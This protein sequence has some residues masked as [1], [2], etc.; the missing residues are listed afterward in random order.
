MRVSAAIPLALTVIF[1]CPL[2]DGKV[3]YVDDDAVGNNDGSS[4]ENAYNYLQDAITIVTGGDLILVA[5]G[6]YKPDQGIGITLGD[7]RTSFHLKNGVAIKG[8]YAGF[9][10]MNPDTRDVGL[11][12]TILSGDL[13]GDDI[14][15]NDPCDLRN[16]PSRADNSSHVVTG[17]NT[18]KTAVLD[19]F[20]ITAG[21]LIA[22]PFMGNSNPDGGAGMYISSGSPTVVDCIF[23]GNATNG[24]G[25]GTINIADSYPTIVNCTF[26]RNYAGGG[27]GISFW[28][29]PE[30]GNPTL[31]D[32]MFDDNYASGDGGGMYNYQSNPNLAN[33]T[34]HCN[35]SQSSG[36]GIYNKMSK[37]EL[38]ECT[39]SENTGFSG[40][41]MYSEDQ[42]ILILMN[43]VF[44][45]NSAEWNG[46]GMCNEDTNDLILTDCTFSDNSA[47]PNGGG[48]FSRRS[49]QMLINCIFSGNKAH[50]GPLPYTYPGK[51]AGLYT[52]GDAEII[53]CVFRNNWASEGAGIYYFQGALTVAG[54]TFTGNSAENYGGG[55]YN[56][57]NMPDLTITNCTF[58][59]NYAEW[60]GGIFNCWRSHLKMSNCT[61]TGNIASNGNAL[62]C[63]PSFTTLPRSIELTNCILWNGNNTLFDPK[64]DDSTIAIAYSDVQ[65]G[66]PG[67]GNI[68][69]NPL[70]ANPGYWA[71]ADDSNIAAEPNDPNAVWIDGDYH[72][73]SQAGRWDPSS[74]SW[75]VDDVT[76]LCIDAGDPNRPVALEPFPNGGIINMGAYG[77]TEEASKSPSGL[78]AKYG[79]GAGE[80]NDPFLIYTAEHLNTIRTEHDW[81]KNFKLMADIDLDPNLPGHKGFDEAIIGNFKGF[82]DGN[83]HRIMHLTIEGDGHLGLFSQ[84]SSEAEVRDLEVVDVNIAGRGCIGGLVGINGGHLVNCFASGTINGTVEEIGGLVGQNY[85]IVEMCHSTGKV[86]GNSFI[87]GLVGE[88]LGYMMVSYSTSDVSGSSKIGGLAGANGTTLAIRGRSGIISDC[89][90]T[91]QV[92]AV[93]GIVGGLVGYN[94]AGNLIR[95]Y[96]TGSVTGNEDIGGLVGLNKDSVIQCFWDIQTSHQA[97]S[98]GGIGKTSAEMQ[99]AGTFLSWSTCGNEGTWTIDEG[100]DYPSLYWENKTGELIVI[101]ASLSELLEGEGLKENP[102]LVYTGE[103]LNYIGL[104]PCDWDK[105]FKLMADIDLSDFDGREGRP[106]FN[107]IGSGRRSRAGVPF[108]GIFDGNGHTIANF[109]YTLQGD[110]ESILKE[111]VENVGL[112]GCIADAN[113]QIRNLGL[114]DPNVDGGTEWNVGCLAG[115]LRDGSITGCYV[116]GGNVKGGNNVGGLIGYNERGNI[117]KCNSTNTNNEADAHNGGLVGYNFRGIISMSYSSGSITARFGRVG[118]L[119]GLNDYSSIDTCYS[120]CTVSIVGSKGSDA[121]GLVGS[122]AWSSITSSYSTGMVTG[123][124][125][126][127]G[128]VG[129]EYKSSSI[130]NFWDIETSGQTTS[131]NGSGKTTAEMQMA[132]TFLEA[133]WDFVDETENGTEDIWW[134]NEGQDYPKLWWE[135]K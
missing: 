3:I 25:G 6:V 93:D 107:I 133:G 30:G 18:D 109:T 134:I 131:A 120:T 117:A 101:G 98:A 32:C 81:D 87:G 106:V 24:Y 58:G 121:G 75:V 55:M 35:L 69:E 116:E 51:G 118:G 70:F 73:K 20:T 62:S 45:A 10:E 8:G 97:T 41:G 132:S 122:N 40:G 48:M 29:S 74:K 1:L 80:P 126:V 72:L 52:F 38:A 91:G 33:C 27:G 112:F 37:L 16:E 90:S 82:F 128:L 26:T 111:Y 76:S 94:A 12:Q 78:H 85:G 39:F 36:G 34:F 64:P 86:R 89:Y 9:S 125:F 31:T 59:G 50:G 79:G 124:Y 61:F 66:W 22:I 130:T 57:D 129:T 88:N 103:E 115:C 56:Y 68:N 65:G 14:E 108:T 102:Y 5:Q 11:F 15:V 119:V 47:N 110:V 63:D 123:N 77:G 17:S 84:L 19:G 28:K 53:D 67:V 4:W 44:R 99:M 46:G 42:C 100:W 60:G 54:C 13:N 104:F 113:S 21:Y 127:G 49:N 71:D 2:A 23:T 43:C 92:S 114:V 7:R 135:N 105:H 95:C 83:G 96:S